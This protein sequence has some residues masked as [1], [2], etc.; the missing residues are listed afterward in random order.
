MCTLSLSPADG[1]QMTSGF[2]GHVCKTAEGMSCSD[3]LDGRLGNC[4]IVSIYLVQIF[5]DGPPCI[6]KI[7][8]GG[9]YYL[10]SLERIL[11]YIPE[12]G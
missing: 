3:L 2:W 7:I 5:I 6:R 1:P 4:F 10:T 12:F 11:S 8:I 9:E